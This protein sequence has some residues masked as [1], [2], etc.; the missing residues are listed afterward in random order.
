MNNGNGVRKAVTG[1]VQ[2]I[3]A[4]VNEHAK[5]ELMLALSLHEIYDQLRDFNVFEQ[6]GTVVGV[7]ALHIVWDDLA[8]IRSL[9]VRQDLCGKGIG[10]RLVESCLVEARGLGIRRIF[11][12]TYQGAF[13]VK[14]GFRPVDKAQLPHKVWN[15]CLKCVKFPDCDEEAFIL[16]LDGTAD[17]R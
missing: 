4:L 8:E 7:S 14:L 5:K 2:G 17:V 11:A 12:L 9:A 13:F 1:D 6:D 10:T 3:Q 15:D 16:E